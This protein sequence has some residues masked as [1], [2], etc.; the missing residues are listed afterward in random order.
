MTTALGLRGWTPGRPIG[1]TNTIF[2]AL[3]G[4]WDDPSRPV[5]APYE[6]LAQVVDALILTLMSRS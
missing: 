4:S 1:G 2:A 5:D 3:I 6:M